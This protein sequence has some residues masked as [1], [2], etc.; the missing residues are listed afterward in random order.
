MIDGTYFANKVCLVLYRDTNIRMTVLYRLTDGERLRELKEDFQ[1]IKHTGIEIESVTCDSAANILKTGREVCPEAVLQRYTVHIAREITTWLTHKT[2]SDAAR[3]LLE[4]VRLLRRVETK[5]EAQLWTRA[6]IDWYRKYEVFVDKQTG[7][8]WYTHKMLRWS[9]SHIHRALPE[10]FAY[11][12]CEKVPKPSNSIE[13][14]FGHLKDKLRI[15]RGLSKE[16]FRNFVKWYLFFNS[17]HDKILQK[18][19]RKLLV[20]AANSKS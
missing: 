4:L 14:F 16:H 20:P 3:E 11:T 9:I 18:S 12:H 2:K 6:F 15:H 7:R 5:E 17:N 10:M 19:Q 1:N 8:W 13:A